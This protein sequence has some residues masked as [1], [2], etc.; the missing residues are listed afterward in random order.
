MPLGQMDIVAS[1][2]CKIN[3]GFALG[4]VKVEREAYLSIITKFS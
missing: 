4:G 1:W 3:P 2:V